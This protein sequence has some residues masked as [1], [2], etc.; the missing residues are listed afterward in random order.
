MPVERAVDRAIRL[1]IR[2]TAEWFNEN[3]RAVASLA[4]G[5]I[6]GQSDLLLSICGEKY[7]HYELFKRLRTHLPRVP[8]YRPFREVGA[9][10]PRRGGRE[11]RVDLAVSRGSDPERDRTNAAAIEV[12]VGYVPF[13]SHSRDPGVPQGW[14]RDTRPYASDFA[15]AAVSIRAKL[16]R[17]GAGY[18]VVLGYYGDDTGW[19]DVEEDWKEDFERA[20]DSLLRDSIV[21]WWNR[22]FL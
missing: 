10:R 6:G 8:E 7:V 5:Q 14:S 11:P 22:R 16:R 21:V 18:L 2:Q 1:S 15:K 12:K 19:G 17:F 4:Y 20:L 13:D 3:V 9:G